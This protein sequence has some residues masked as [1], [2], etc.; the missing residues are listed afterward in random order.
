MAAPRCS[1]SD[2]N[3]SDCRRTNTQT[4]STR[5]S[6]T[7]G[8]IPGGNVTGVC[9]IASELEVKR[10]A[11]LIKLAVRRVVAMAADRKIVKAGFPPLRKAAAEVGLEPVEIWVESPSE[12]AAAFDAMRGHGVEALVIAPLPELHRDRKCSPR[13]RQKP[14]CRP[15]SEASERALNKA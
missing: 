12:Y 7:V 14:D 2:E 10:L 3:N 13:F 11:L 8:C 4:Q 9:L 5:V 15:I 6:P 1:R